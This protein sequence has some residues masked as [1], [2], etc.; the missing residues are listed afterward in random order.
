VPTEV[1][2][3]AI[4]HMAAGSVSFLALIAACYV[5]SRRFARAGD[6]RAA[7]LSVVAGTALLAGDLWAMTGG[8]A[9]S[10]TLAAGAVTAMLWVSAACFRTPGRR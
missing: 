9:G 5:L 10:L 2:G 8:P 1:S 7:A 6:R 4:G 3:H